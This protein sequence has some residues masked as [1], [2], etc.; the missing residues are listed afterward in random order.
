MRGSIRRR[1]ENSCQVRVS[2]GGDPETGRYRY[3]GRY[4]KG[5]KRDA[6][7]AWAGL[8]TEV[9]R[10][11]HRHERRH[12][13]NELLDRWMARIEAQGRADS[14]LARY[15]S[16]IDANIKP[17]LGSKGINRLGPAEIDRFYGQLARTAR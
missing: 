4:V 17:R 9:D 12:T 3:V 10:G 11:G 15:R 16:C 8:V 5:T 14:T 6:Q 2:L 1:G 13:I 7:R